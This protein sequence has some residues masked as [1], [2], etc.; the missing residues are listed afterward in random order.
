VTTARDPG[1]GIAGVAGRG[2]SPGSAGWVGH[3]AQQLETRSRRTASI[4]C[5]ASAEDPGGAN[6]DA[7]AVKEK[8]AT[9]TTVRPKIAPAIRQAVRSPHPDEAVGPAEP[10]LKEN[11]GGTRRPALAPA[12]PYVWLCQMRHRF[13]ARIPSVGTYTRLVKRRSVTIT[14]GAS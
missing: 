7:A 8:R 12:S 2:P 5:S 14:S 3:H 13:A 9:W 10:V 11:K 4:G 1:A 6:T